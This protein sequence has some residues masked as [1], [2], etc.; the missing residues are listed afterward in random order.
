MHIDIS[1]LETIRE[2]NALI[3]KTKDIS[4][5]NPF[6]KTEKLSLK[7]Q[8]LDRANS[9]QLTKIEASKVQVTIG[10]DSR[11]CVD[12]CELVGFVFKDF[13]FVIEQYPQFII[14]YQ[15][16]SKLYYTRPR[17]L[18]NIEDGVQLPSFITSSKKEIIEA[19]KDIANDIVE[20]ITK[21]EI[22]VEEFN[23]GE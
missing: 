14:Y 17:K 10:Q 23:K 4:I 6:V 1:D 11:E 7:S 15:G 18:N 16:L 8:I 2:G 20:L 3:G 21:A 9:I 5:A 22:I 12:W 13:K 19:I